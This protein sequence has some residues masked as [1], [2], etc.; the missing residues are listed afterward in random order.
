MTEKKPERRQFSRVKFDAPV[1][2]LRDAQAWEC[3]V[4]DI[5]LKGALIAVP[6]GLHA[7]LN[8]ELTLELPLGDEG[9]T[10]RMTVAV[11][12]IDAYRAGLRCEHIDIES[13][14]HLR[15]LM[16]LNLGDSELLERELSELG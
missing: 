2:I 4:L 11:A 13:F 9:S 16:E 6:E 15:R 1:R 7:A 10:I 3:E 14:I 8:D 12:H 5:S